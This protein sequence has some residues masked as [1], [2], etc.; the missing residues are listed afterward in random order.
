MITENADIVRGE[1][2]IPQPVLEA[3]PYDSGC[4]HIMRIYVK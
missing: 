1:R 4:G 2:M 3:N